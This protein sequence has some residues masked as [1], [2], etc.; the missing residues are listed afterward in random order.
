[1]TQPHH[2]PGF[3][4]IL[5]FA[6]LYQIP[7]TVEKTGNSLNAPLIPFRIQLRRSHKQLIHPQRIAAVITHQV[8]R[9]DHIAFGFT[10]LDAVLAGDHALVEQLGKGFV[11]V[12]HSD[13]VKELGVEP[14]VQKMQYRM[15]HTADIHIYR[16]ILVRLLPGHQLFVIVAVHISQEIPRGTSPLGHGIRLSLRRPP[17]LRAGTVHPLIDC[18]QRR[19]SGTS[20]LIALHLRQL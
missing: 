5:I 20:G 13:I 6:G 2:L 12:H 15:L 4:R 17:T 11:K 16:Q 1:M 3:C 8:I 19:L 9:R 14:G 7:E 10:H 18:C